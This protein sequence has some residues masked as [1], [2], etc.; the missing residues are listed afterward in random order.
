MGDDPMQDHPD[1]VNGRAANEAEPTEAELFPVGSLAGDSVTAQTLV[2]R[3]L[4][5][6]VTVSLAMAEVPTK[7]GLVDPNR[8]GRVLVSYVPGKV[9]HVPERDDDGKVKGWKLRQHLRPTF[10]ADAN[11]ETSVARN[12]FAAL[13]AT[14][15]PAAGALLA[16]LRQLAE[17]E[18]TTA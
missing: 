1:S 17:A 3:G 15:A 16:E 8:S 7:D 4:P 11:D 14:D 12:A 6:A 9:E 10:V 13:L 5:T 2:R 18:L